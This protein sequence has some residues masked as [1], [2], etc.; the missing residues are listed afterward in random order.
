MSEANDRLDG[1]P[2][3]EEIKQIDQKQECVLPHLP[4]LRVLGARTPRDSGVLRSQFEDAKYQVDK[5]LLC[6]AYSKRAM[7]SS[8]SFPLYTKHIHIHTQLFVSSKHLVGASKHLAP[9]IRSRS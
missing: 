8:D 1:V 9:L 6:G 4:S 5:H 7:M 3:Q 2:C